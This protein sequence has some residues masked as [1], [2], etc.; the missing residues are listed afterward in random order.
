MFGMDEPTS[1]I[2]GFMRVILVS[3]MLIWS[4]LL[5]AQTSSQAFRQTV[6]RFKKEYPQLNIQPLTLS[7]VTNIQNVASAK[8]LKEQQCFFES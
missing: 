7:Y 2:N 6:E 3:S 5:Q 8:A 1:Q 4:V